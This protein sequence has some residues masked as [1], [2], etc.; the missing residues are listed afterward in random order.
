M[1]TATTDH[2]TII[3]A[4]THAG[5]NH[6]T[7][8]EYLDPKYVPDFDAWREQVQ[9]PVEGPARHRACGSATGTTSGATP[10]RTPTASS[11][12]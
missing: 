2:Y 5:A 8:R 11:A 6:E 12:R 7:Y 10:T 9:E 4:D 1:A 3:S